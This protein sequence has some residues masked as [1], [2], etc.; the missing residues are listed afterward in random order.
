MPAK[1]TTEIFIERSKKTHKN[2]YCYSHVDYKGIDKP[3]DILCKEHGLFRQKAG[4]HMNGSDCPKCAKANMG[5]LVTRRQTKSTEQFISE[6]KSIYGD[7]YDYS[8]TVYINGKVKVKITCRKHGIFEIRPNDFLKGHQCKKCWKEKLS[9]QRLRTNDEFISM[10]NNI[11]NGFYDYGKTKYTKSSDKII[12]ICPI[13]G[14]F[15]IEANSHIQGKGCILCGFER[16]RLSR[17]KSKEDFVTQAHEIHNYKYDYS[18]T[19]YINDKT[20]IC[21]ICSVHGAFWQIPNNHLNGAGCPNCQRSLLCESV[22]KMLKCNDIRY[23]T[24]YKPEWLK[25]PN[26]NYYLPLDIFLLDYNIGIE[27]QGEQHFKPVEYFGGMDSYKALVERD[28]IK[29]NI[30]KENGINVLYFCK[31]KNIHPNYSENLFDDVEDLCA[32]IKNGIDTKEFGEKL[33]NA[34]LY[35]SEVSSDDTSVNIKI[36]GDSND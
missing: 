31:N 14:D 16:T 28:K 5:Q 33:L 26:T 7:K 20:K 23:E 19:E 8:E 12:V 34:A 13:H 25:N 17:L 4:I 18:K 9:E 21:I 1:L 15:E 36:G 3:V 6:A 35:G 10:A 24:E 32:A 29:R 27:C 2:Q 30:C 11:H 22:I